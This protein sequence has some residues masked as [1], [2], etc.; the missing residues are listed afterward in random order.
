MPIFSFCAVSL[1]VCTATLGPWAERSGPRKVATAAAFA[2]GGGLALSGLG[3]EL[4]QIGLLY[5][6]YGVLGG[7]GWGLGYISPVSTLMKW[8]PDR[9]GMPVEAAL[10]STE[11]PCYFRNNNES[12]QDEKAPR[13][14]GNLFRRFPRWLL[15]AVLFCCLACAVVKKTGPRAS[16]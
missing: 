5:A 10:Q 1:G 12:R 7:A 16:R 3:C 11:S 14:F 6:G 2:W 15:I 8:F 13:I 9:R 4:N